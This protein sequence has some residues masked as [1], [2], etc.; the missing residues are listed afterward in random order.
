MTGK[1]IAVEGGDATGKGTLVRSLVE[2]LNSEGLTSVTVHPW[3]NTDVGKKVREIIVNTQGK[4]DV[5][6]R[7]MLAC[8]AHRTL[9]EETIRPILAKG[10]NVVLDR[11][12]LSTFVYQGILEGATMETVDNIRRAGGVELK[13]DTTLVLMANTDTILNRIQNRAGEESDPMDFKD[14]VHHA[15]V[16]QA[17]IQASNRYIGFRPIFIDADKTPDVVLRESVHAL[18]RPG[19]FR[20]VK[21]QLK[22]GG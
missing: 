5:R 6:T 20:M 10:V 12:L 18:M 21:G 13:F 3:V 7:I 11:C 14:A 15:R 22:R 8:A 19:V 17:Y 1:L 4:L 2:H 9:Q 16:R